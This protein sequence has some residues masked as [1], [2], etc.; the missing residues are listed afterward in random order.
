MHSDFHVFYRHDFRDQEP[1][2][3]T[4][5]QHIITQ[6]DCLY[7]SNENAFSLKTGRIGPCNL[8][9]KLKHTHATEQAIEP[10]RWLH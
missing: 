8:E 2:Q 9:W 1:F 7:W 10:D 4:T 6:S 5:L 3:W